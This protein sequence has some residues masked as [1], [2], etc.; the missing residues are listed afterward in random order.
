MTRLTKILRVLLIVFLLFALLI[1]YGWSRWQ[2]FK[3][4]HGL[5]V[6]W[7]G[8]GI[9]FNGLTIKQLTASQQATD[10][11]LTTINSQNIVLSWSTLTIKHLS[12][13]WQQGDLIANTKKQQEQQPLDIPS[14]LNNLSWAPNT[15]K[16]DDLIITLPCATGQCKTSGAVTLLQNQQTNLPFSLQAQL[17]NNKDELLINANLYKKDQQYD[18][19]LTTNFNKQP[20]LALTTQIDNQQLK[21][22][23]GQLKLFKIEDTQA[24]FT[25]L[26]EWLPAQQAITEIPQAMEINA[27]WQ[28]H[29]PNG[30]TNFKPNQGYFNLDA[31]LPNPWP[32][33]KLG[34]LQG[35]I[36]TKVTLNNYRPRI[37]KLD[38]DVKLT[39]LDQT[40]LE[41]L[42]KDLQPNSVSLTLQPLAINDSHPAADRALTIHLNI[43]GVTNTLFT[44]NIFINTKQSEIQLEEALL[45]AN[46]KKLTVLGYNI[47]NG[48]LSLPFKATVNTKQTTIAFDKTSVITLAQVTS[49]EI[50]AKNL[51]IVASNLITTINYEDKDNIKV[52]AS[53][54]IIISASSLIHAMLKSISWRLT[55]QLVADLTQ[56]SFTGK[57]NNGADLSADITVKTDYTKQL[58]ITAKTPDLFFRTSNMFAKTFK[59]WPEL[60][61]IATGKINLNGSV[62]IPLANGLLKT[63]ATAKFSGLSGIFDRS[64]FTDLSGSAT[65]DLQNNRLKISSTDL[66]LTEANPGIIMGPAQFKGDYTA[67]L[68]NLLQGTVNWTKMELGMFTGEVWL[69]PGQLNLAKLPQQLNLQIKDLQ[70]T[71]ILKAYPTEG[72]DG[73]G[74]LDGKLPIII[75][76]NGIEVKE[77][78]LEARKAGFIKFDSP[79]I[80]AMGQ[81]NPSMQLVTEALENFQYTILNSQ[82]SYDQGTATLGLQI[83]GRNPNVKNGQLIN[84]NITLEEDIPAL[85]TTLQLSDRVSE[86]IRD[87]VQKRLQ[88]RSSKN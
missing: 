14:L 77:G 55:G 7:Q 88:Q 42:P 1:V 37:E 74:I 10:G 22:W 12:V 71:D 82:V 66:T 84:L 27:D 36:K 4:D 65:I 8:L 79:S 67:T 31:S 13:Q 48:R 72:L 56:M 23:Q 60:L 86:T 62:T 41:Q 35:V 24:L 85:M 11:S 52:T 38:T 75:S 39:N 29:F 69:K 76:K 73:E 68:N 2:I 53:S 3:Y 30:I 49:K 83:S 18:L 81:N 17:H 61:E 64:E 46:S 57:I 40:L 34:Y 9:G 5:E 58:A 70:L 32:I 54:P 15:I 51:Q 28:L 78:K 6:N 21:D 25:W 44:S 45:Q 20:L 50:G 59:D 43:E 87:R 47:E 16:I 80:K 19:K 63:N 33:I 26:H